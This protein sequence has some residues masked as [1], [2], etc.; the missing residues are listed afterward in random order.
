MAPYTTID[1]IDSTLQTLRSIFQSN[2][3]KD[4]RYRKWQLKQLYWLV[5]DNLDDIIL[6]LHTDLRAHEFE[7]R[8]TLKDL[9]D[10]ISYHIS[11]VESWAKDAV[12]DSGFVFTKVGQTAVRHEP[13]GVVLIIG[14]WNYPVS[15]TLKPLASA[16]AAGCCAIIK[17]SEVASSTADLMMS[18]APKY[19]D[20]EAYAFVSGGAKET[21]YMLMH[22]FDHIFF[23]GST[24]VGKHIAA[25][26]AKHLTPCVLELGGQIPAI[27]TKTANV[28]LAAKR[29]A[30][31][32]FMNAGQVC[33]SVNHTFVDPDVHEEFLERIIHWNDKF[34][35]NEGESHMSAIVNERHHTRVMNVL[36]TTSGTIVCGGTS[37]SHSLKLPPTVVSGV[38]LSDTLMKQELF[39]PILPI[40]AT[41]LISAV[42]TISSMPHSLALYIFSNDHSEID[43]ILNNTISGGVTVNDCLLHAGAQGAPFGG[44][45][46]SGYGSYNGRYGFDAFTHKRTVVRLPNWLDRFMGFRY[47]PYDVGKS[48]NYIMPAQPEFKRGET[49]ENQKL[50]G[51]RW[52]KWFRGYLA[53]AV[54]G[55]AVAVMYQRW[56]AQPKEHC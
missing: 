38:Q 3:T 4:I 35:A 41:D 21:E 37:S 6:A 2:R 13:R 48:K 34:T 17:P 9:L 39:A 52:S 15:L 53:G 47:P 30:W 1:E 54:F 45:G 8:F 22:K 14:A 36:E 49:L 46:E 12:P 23:T 20:P 28:D 5:F 32:K 24:Q 43:F 55:G 40:L 26:A 7:A 42:R 56:S 18:L 29:I 33:L 31:A 11:H 51:D 16:I 10:T 50:G 25:A 44:V 19:L 27:V